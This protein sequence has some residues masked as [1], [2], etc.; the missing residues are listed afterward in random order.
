M[1]HARTPGYARTRVHSGAAGGKRASNVVKR[2]QGILSRKL[3]A[4]TAVTKSGHNN[5]SSDRTGDSLIQATARRRVLG[6]AKKSAAA[7]IVS[8]AC[9]G[10]AVGAPDDRMLPTTD[11][12]PR[13]RAAWKELAA[14]RE[15]LVP[16]PDARPELAEEFNAFRERVGTLWTAYAADGITYDAA[17]GDALLSELYV[18]NGHPIFNSSNQNEVARIIAAVAR[19]PAERMPPGVRERLASGLIEY[20]DLGGGQ[21]EPAV[22]AQVATALDRLAPRDARAQQY[23]ERLLQDAVAWTEEVD[24]LRSAVEKHSVEHWG[25]GFALRRY[26]ATLARAALPPNPPKRYKQGVA[27]LAELLSETARDEDEQLA[28]LRSATEAALQR[29][30]DRNLVDDLTCRLLIVYRVLLGRR[31]VIAEHGSAYIEERLMWLVRQPERLRTEQHWS[32]WADAVNEIGWMRTSDGT[33]DFIK[34]LKG[35]K[36]LSQECRHALERLRYVDSERK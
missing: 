29:L 4:S 17:M 30:S 24:A 18:E 21:D 16:L 20:V 35:R 15:N 33:R 1:F 34:A 14:E 22:E 32:L 9:L 31:P 26:E 13:D 19:W 11:V 10:V 12:W 27:K 23:V 6:E 8:L 2:S 3:S 28:R 36:D 5:N 7:V 25:E